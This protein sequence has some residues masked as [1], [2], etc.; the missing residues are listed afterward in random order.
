MSHSKN[1]P[2]WLG[3]ARMAHF[4]AECLRLESVDAICEAVLRI[5]GLL[6]NMAASCLVEPVDEAPAAA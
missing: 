3:L 1:E 6:L 5:E 2:E 4:E